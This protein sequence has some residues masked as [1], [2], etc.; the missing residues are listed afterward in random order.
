MREK[1]IFEQ[2]I[3]FAKNLTRF[4]ND[5]KIKKLIYFSSI[6]I[7]GKNNEKII[8]EQSKKN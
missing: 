2:N 6:S 8:S 4:C 1:N 5:K 7:Y 3:N